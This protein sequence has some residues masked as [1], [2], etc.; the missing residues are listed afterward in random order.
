ML[1]T[2]EVESIHLLNSIALTHGLLEKELLQEL[3][4]YLAPYCEMNLELCINRTLEEYKDEEETNEE[5]AVIARNTL[6]DILSDAR[7]VAPLLLT[8]KHHAP[9]NPET[10]TFFYVFAHRTASKAYVVSKQILTWLF[11]I[12]N[13]YSSEIKLTM[14]KNCLTSSVFLW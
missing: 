10:E 6:L 11:N 5:K 3:R 12:I 7:T 13:S 2:S 14:A 1:G 9:L 4:D 8:A